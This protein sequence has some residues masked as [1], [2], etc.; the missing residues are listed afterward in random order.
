MSK[1]F[2]TEVLHRI[3]NDDTGECLEVGPDSDSL[4]G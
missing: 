2:S 4:A 1:G 3:Y